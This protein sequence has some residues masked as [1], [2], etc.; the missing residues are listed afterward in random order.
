M[1]QGV[2]H[3]S[4]PDLQPKWDGVTDGAFGSWRDSLEAGISD[5]T[6]GWRGCRIAAFA[7]GAG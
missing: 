2:G 1:L 6:V 7:D 5:M 4:D 3:D